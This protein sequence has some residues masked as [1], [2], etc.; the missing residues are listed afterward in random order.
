[1]TLD[2]ILQEMH[3]RIGQIEYSLSCRDLPVHEEEDLVLE[4]WRLEGL[5]EYEYKGG[6]L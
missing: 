6:S 5:V 1:M 4:L 3:K 2:D